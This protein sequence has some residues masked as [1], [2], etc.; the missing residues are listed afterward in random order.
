MRRCWDIAATSR[1]KWCI[2]ELIQCDGGLGRTLGGG[3][4]LNFAPAYG[5]LT[6]ASLRCWSLLSRRGKL[7]EAESPE[8]SAVVVDSWWTVFAF[9]GRSFRNLG[10]FFVL[11]LWW[12]LS[13]F[14]IRWLCATWAPNVIVK[15]LFL[16]RLLKCRFYSF[17]LTSLTLPIKSPILLFQ[18]L[19]Q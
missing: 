17:F 12:M 2:G 7:T 1:S 6:A 15:T 3:G 16:L 10:L 13:L 19:L 8:L 9:I 5:M 14:E 4:L 18:D 11:F